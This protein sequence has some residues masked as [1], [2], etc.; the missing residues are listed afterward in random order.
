MKLT[1]AEM[2]SV[3]AGTIDGLEAVRAR[4]AQQLLRAAIKS[5]STVNVDGWTFKRTS[6]P[7]HDMR[8]QH[9][10]RV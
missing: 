4:T 8:A 6:A 10:E 1:S 2:V 3:L 9:W 7:L 5:S